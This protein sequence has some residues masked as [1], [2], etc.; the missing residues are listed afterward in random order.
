LDASWQAFFAS[1]DGWQLL[2]IA[3]KALTYGT[4]FVASGGSLFSVIFHAQLSEPERISIRVVT[5]VSAV[6]C[7]ALSVL[8]ILLMNVMMSDDLSGA[9]DVEMA[10]NILASTEGLAT[11]MR[12]T[13]SMLLILLPQASSRRGFLI[14]PLLGAALVALSFG[15]VGHGVALA[16]KCGPMPQWQICVHLLAVA[17]WLGALWPLHRATYGSDPTQVA[18]LMQR[19]GKMAV[20]VVAVLVGAGASLLWQLLGSPKAMWQT[21]YG[22]LMLGKLAGVACLM[23]FAAINK[24]LLTPRIERGERSAILSLRR[25]IRA[26]LL[27]LGLIL[28]VTAVL[29]TSV[30]APVLD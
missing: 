3:T 27:F 16:T 29:T 1:V 26:E 8:R 22:I 6:S 19:F 5:F 25:S 24:L 20:L 9:L 13:G 14:F 11:G 12:M 4:C 10:G 18:A 30:G 23:G 17:F 21:T 15:Q 2:V 28:L 7:I